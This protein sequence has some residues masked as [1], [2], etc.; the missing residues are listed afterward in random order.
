M[1]SKLWE[2]L[3]ELKS[4]AYEWVDLSHPVNEETPHYA[5]YNKLEMTEVFTYDEHTVCASE[6]KMVSQY[7]THIDPPSHFVEGGSI[8][9]PY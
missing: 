5:G 3:D 6:Y 2:L 8:W 1:S 7:G 4:P 9:H